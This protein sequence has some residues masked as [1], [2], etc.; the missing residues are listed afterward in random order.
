MSTDDETTT[1]VTWTF[2]CII[3]GIRTHLFHQF[4]DLPFYSE[5][6]CALYD[7]W[8]DSTSYVDAT[9]GF[10][11][12]A[13]QPEA[14]AF[15]EGDTAELHREKAIFLKLLQSEGQARIV[16][17]AQIQYNAIQALF[18]A[19]KENFYETKRVA[20]MAGYEEFLG[21]ET[22]GERSDD[23]NQK[24]AN[25]LSALINIRRASA[26]RQ[27]SGWLTHMDDF[28]SYWGSIL[29]SITGVTHTEILDNV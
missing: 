15:H 12:L 21:I 29:P 16:K 28:L 23:S 1:D 6:H 25:C 20:R 26:R 10:D 24:K 17:N 14:P 4:Y 9:D 13:L 22:P 11:L 19:Y 2:H 18:K 5:M 27:E 8:V 7:S 3:T